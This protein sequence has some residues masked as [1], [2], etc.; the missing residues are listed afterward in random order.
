MIDSDINLFKNLSYVLI[1]NI[2]NLNYFIKNI[3][4]FLENLLV[5]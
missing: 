1:N 3:I 5:Y 2:L 4:L